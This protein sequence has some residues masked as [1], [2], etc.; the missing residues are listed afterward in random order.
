[1]WTLAVKG[2]APLADGG[3]GRI[4][5]GAQS[6]AAGQQQDETT[7]RRRDTRIRAQSSAVWLGQ[8]YTNFK[9]IHTD[10]VAPRWPA[11]KCLNVT[12]VLRSIRA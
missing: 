12:T 11:L 7:E 4:T 2:G 5:L 6:K 3:P 9:D 8:E 1:M 10:T